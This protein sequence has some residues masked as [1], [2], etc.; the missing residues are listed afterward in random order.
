M[1][2]LESL[3]VPLD[4]LPSPLDLDG[5][6]YGN[7]GGTVDEEARGGCRG[8]SAGADSRRGACNGNRGRVAIVGKRGSA[9]VVIVGG[10]IGGGGGGV[11]ICG[12]GG[13]G[14]GSGMTP[15]RQLGWA[16]TPDTFDVLFAV[17]VGVGAAV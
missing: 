2:S 10:A 16:P 5:D 12:G 13:V 14:A 15:R 8:S 7:G 3:P 6:T 1:P 17:A 9:P 11:I 4:S